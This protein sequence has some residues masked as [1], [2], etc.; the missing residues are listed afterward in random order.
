MSAYDLSTS[1]IQDLVPCVQRYFN[2]C[3]QYC[4]MPAHAHDTYE[5]DY[6][7]SGECKMTVTDSQTGASNTV[8]LKAGHYIFFRE[9]V[10]HDFL[11]ERGSPC[12][13]RNIEFVFR[14]YDSLPSL[15]VLASNTNC[16]KFLTA[17][18][19]YC[20][21]RDDGIFSSCLD[22]LHEILLEL[23]EEHKLIREMPDMKIVLTLLLLLQRMAEQIDSDIETTKSYDFYIRQAIEYIKGNYENT[24]KISITD[25]AQYVRIAPA[26]LQRMF[27][28]ETGM[29]IIEYISSVRLEKAKF[30]LRKTDM[31]ILDIALN[32][33]YLS[34]QRLFQLFK[35][36]EGISPGQYRN[37]HRKKMDSCQMHRVSGTVQKRISDQ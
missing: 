2:A 32:V 34:R 28:A 8:T 23:Y 22:L 37:K 16:T 21:V 26:Y 1:G 29:T 11:V 15:S 10:K 25:I 3:Y 31:P 14:N 12:R 7:A 35:E 33:G 6:V 19:D 9:N 27:K 30:L 36:K 17:V 5:I 4:E 13:I 20:V 24:E 18:P